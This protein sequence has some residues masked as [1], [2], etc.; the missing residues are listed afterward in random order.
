MRALEWRGTMSTA[1]SNG[2]SGKLGRRRFI[3]LL[4]ATTMA[5]SLAPSAESE[6]DRQLPIGDE[7]FLDHI[8][9]FVPDQDAASRALSRAGFTPTPVSIQVNPDPKG[10]PPQL[11]GTGNVTAMLSRGYIEVL[12]KTA[13]TTLGRELD[14]AMARYA[15]VHLAAFVV[16]DAAGAH[17]RL[18][19]DGFRVRPLVSLQRPV[20]TGAGSGTAAF[21][22]ARVEPGEMPEGRIQML[23]HHTEDTVWQTRW[24]GHPNGA[25]APPASPM[26]CRRLIRSPRRRGRAAW[27]E[28]QGRA[29]WRS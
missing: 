24:L 3:T 20:D 23:T 28:F 13:D 18:R 10:G 11:T 12:F 15:G 7:I 29:P 1:N 26:N 22:V 17:R 5:G 16:A 9:H 19:E 4:G 6:A 25:I 21:T 8:G 2:S 27:A 14:T